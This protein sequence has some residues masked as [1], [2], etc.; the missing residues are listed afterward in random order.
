MLKAL[1]KYEKSENF[2]GKSLARKRQ[3]KGMESSK[4]RW[5]SLSEVKAQ[6][7][8]RLMKKIMKKSEE[9]RVMWT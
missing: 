2:S 4:V 3:G 1:R 5:N 7:F 9:K 8:T 6:G